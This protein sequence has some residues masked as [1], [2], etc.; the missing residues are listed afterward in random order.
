MSDL[1]RKPAPD[2]ND[3]TLTG[4]DYVAKLARLRAALID[5]EESG[6]TDSFDLDTFLREKRARYQPRREP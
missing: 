6:R 5:G 4:D 3:S 2:R 1:D